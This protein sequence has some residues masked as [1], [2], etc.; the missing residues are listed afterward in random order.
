[1]RSSGVLERYFVGRNDVLGPVS[2]KEK[3]A[4]D[5]FDVD[6]PPLH[7]IDKPEPPDRR[8]PL[9]LPALPEALAIRP[10]PV[11]K[12]AT[13][14]LPEAFREVAVG[15][16]GRFLIFHF[17]N[18]RKLGIFDVNEAKITSFI[19]VGEDQVHFAAGMTKLLVFLPT[20]KV[21]Q[22]WN[23]INQQREAIGKLDVSGTV[24]SFCMGSAS[25]G[26]LLISARQGHFGT[27][28]VHDIQ[29]FEA[30]RLPTRSNARLDEGPYWAAANGRVFGHSGVHGLPNGI[31]SIVLEADSVRSFN[32]HQ[33]SGYVQ[34][35]PDGKHVYVG[36]HGVLTQ[37]V[38][39]AAD[40]AVS[41][42]KD[43]AALDYM[44]L[45][46]HHDLYYMH[47]ILQS[48][49]SLYS[50][51]VNVD[52][53]IPGITFYLMGYR[54]RIASLE[55]REVGDLAGPGGYAVSGHVHLVP[56]ARLL[57]L[58]PRERDRLRLFRLD[59]DAELEGSDIKY[60]LVTSR[61]PIEAPRGELLRYD[62][63]CKTRAGGLTFKL[64]SGPK[65]MSINDKGQLR[66]R[67]PADFA[68]AEPS[69]IVS[70]R[71]KDGQ[72]IFHSFALQVPL[73]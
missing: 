14:K 7:G 66:W 61:P 43:G 52:D 19:A 33:C 49:N 35:G 55:L 24:Y 50:Q 29:T 62:I 36:G 65:G 56:R 4:I 68:D 32:Q 59:L 44:F 57:V 53:P 22:R 39:V 41:R 63:Q 31:T 73:K 37:Q 8:P 48:P 30:M 9:R 46:A 6:P 42:I 64:E 5:P 18:L 28:A 2:R 67:V 70:I 38:E 16:D 69:I 10:A 51:P 12:E 26:P 71:D 1:M 40:A 72:E 23:L 17:P 11:E 45:P 58:I 25:D 27:A 3:P 60:L 20:S 34:P 15:G 13:L 47:V 54:Q 21:I